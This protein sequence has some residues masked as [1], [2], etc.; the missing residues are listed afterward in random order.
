MGRCLLPRWIPAPPAHSRAD[1]AASLPVHL[2]RSRP[3]L[4]LMSTAASAPPSRKPGLLPFAEARRRVHELQLRSQQQYKRWSK[5]ERPASIP[6]APERAYRGEGWLSWRDWLG[7]GQGLGPV[8][9][10]LPFEEARRQVQ[11]ARL[12]GW[13]D[14]RRWARD[15][16]PKNIPSHPDLTYAEEGWLSW[17]DWLGHGQGL[18][19]VG[20]F[21]SFEEARRQVQEA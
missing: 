13:D 17:R 5:L 1:A 9:E 10:F 18:G 15:A 6:S 11:E 2:W 16:R 14:W 12:A 8:G 4:A 19:P 20:A 21:A 3:S 7:Y